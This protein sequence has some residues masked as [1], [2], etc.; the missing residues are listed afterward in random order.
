M[1]NEDDRKMIPPDPSSLLST[2]HPSLAPFVLNPPPSPMLTLHVKLSRVLGYA[3]L[4]LSTLIPVACGLEDKLSWILTRLRTPEL[5]RYLNWRRLQDNTPYSGRIPQISSSAGQ[6]K[7]VMQS[8]AWMNHDRASRI[9]VLVYWVV[10]NVYLFDE[11]LH[12]VLASKVWKAR[13]I[14]SKFS[15]ADWWPHITKS[16][17]WFV[18]FVG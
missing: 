17:H 4:P 7:P 8:A 6:P 1:T 5:P 9:D 16:F 2:S 18:I 14:C 11:P 3:F 12:I 10:N 13:L 15:V